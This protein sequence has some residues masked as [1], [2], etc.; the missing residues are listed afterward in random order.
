M[1]TAVPIPQEIQQELDRLR[2]ENLNL[3]Q[4]LNKFGLRFKTYPEQ[5]DAQRIL[6]G[7]TPFLKF[8]TEYS[9]IKDNKTE[10]DVPHLLIEGDNLPAL[11][12]LQ[13]THQGKVDVI[14]IDP[15]YNTGNKDFVYNDSFV[16]NDDGFRHSKW[17]S[18]M[19]PRLELTKNLLSDEGIIIVAIDDNEHATLKLLMDEIYGEQNRIASVIWDGGLKNNSRFVSEGHDYMLVYAKNRSTLVGRDVSWRES[20][21]GV[22]AFL[23][24]ADKLKDMDATQAEKQSLLKKWIRENSGSLDKGLKAYSFVD[25]EGRVY[26][27]G[28]L[29]AP[30]GNGRHYDVL[31]PITGKPVKVPSRGWRTSETTMRQMVLGGEISFGEDET[32]SPRFKRVL[33]SEANIDQVVRSY[34][35]EER[36]NANKALQRILG[37]N[38]F[39]FPK[40]TNVLKRWINL[41]TRGK[42]DVIVLDFFAGSGSTG[43]AVAKLNAEDGGTRQA[44]LITNNFDEDG[45]ENGIA[46][47]ITA[48]R[49]KRVLTGENWADG[50]EHESL[51]G[52]LY[53]Y[54][55]EF[56]DG[57]NG[58]D[59]IGIVSI[60]EESYSVIEQDVDDTVIVLEG[61]DALI[62]VWTDAEQLESYDDMD[63]EGNLMSEVRIQKM[64]DWF[65]SRGENVVWYVD[66]AVYNIDYIP[67]EELFKEGETVKAVRSLKGA[68]L[69]KVVNTRNLLDTMLV[70]EEEPAPED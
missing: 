45:V 30:G 40:D 19:K 49:M 25:D 43:E 51:P 54:Q 10:S 21:K 5:G 66:T 61:K 70:K 67:E 26:T 33:S 52:E 64:N 18:F 63:D 28:D 39:N 11:M 31:H 3:Q 50:K 58:E 69:N 38:V 7:E 22:E 23:A 20:K 16:S 62:A 53:Y 4:K 14:Y 37:N 65:T 27:R 12:A 57:E 41:V 34:F 60:M 56:S 68:Y 47:G 8:N 15:P 55:V 36:S 42:K 24:F 48:E 13:S 32:T 46:R 6:R 1:S 9:V 59:Y 44:I 35:W 2:G 29:S 17:L